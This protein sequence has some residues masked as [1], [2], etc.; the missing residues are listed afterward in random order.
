[1]RTSDFVIREALVPNLVATVKG[2]ASLEGVFVVGERTSA[3]APE[4]R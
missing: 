3:I 2:E 1:M 4:G